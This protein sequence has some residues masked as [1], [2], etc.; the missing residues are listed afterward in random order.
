MDE[1]VSRVDG[2][3]RCDVNCS[4]FPVLGVGTGRYGVD[5]TVRGEFYECD[6]ES[7]M[8]G[9]VIPSKTLSNF[10]TLKNLLVFCALSFQKTSINANMLFSV[11]ETDTD[12]THQ[13]G[14]SSF[15]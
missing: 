9:N 14:V 4:L 10:S 7:L 2:H 5:F 11:P 12:R 3:C 8:F 6:G 15:W 13:Q 1:V